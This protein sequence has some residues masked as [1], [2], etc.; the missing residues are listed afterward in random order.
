MQPTK[1]SGQVI[2]RDNGLV[3]SQVDDG[4]GVAIGLVGRLRRGFDGV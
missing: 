4:I 3:L 1:R 2:I